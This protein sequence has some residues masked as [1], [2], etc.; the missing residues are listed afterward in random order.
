[1]K[2]YT[3]QIGQGTGAAITHL[4]HSESIFADSLLEAIDKAKAITNT[5][6]PHAAET[7]V[8]IVESDADTAT[9][10]VRPIGDVRA[11]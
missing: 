3:Y 2:A 6:P 11:G 9:A 7:T 10:W 4:A 8:R 1:M 5:R